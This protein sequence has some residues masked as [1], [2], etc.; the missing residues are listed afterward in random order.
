M[1]KKEPEPRYRQNVFG[2]SKEGTEGWNREEIVDVISKY[3]GP[4]WYRPYLTLVDRY[5]A[6]LTSMPLSSHTASK[7]P[8][9]CG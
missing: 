1:Q 3:D 5:L 9:M 7:S 2:I 8:G 6:P 4:S